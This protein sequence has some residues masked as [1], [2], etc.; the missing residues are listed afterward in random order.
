MDNAPA[1]TDQLYIRPDALTDWLES[2]IPQAPDGFRF[3]ARISPKATLVE[4]LLV[5]D[6]PAAEVSDL[7]K[8]LESVPP[9]A[10]ESQSDIIESA[11]FPSEPLTL[12]H[13]VS[14][15]QGAQ[16]ILAIASTAENNRNVWRALL[17]CISDF[18]ESQNDCL[19]LSKEN[20]ELR[21]QE[22]KYHGIFDNVVEGIYQTSRDG[23]YLSVNRMLAQIYGYENPQALMENIRNIQRDLYVDPA[24]RE[25]FVR[26]LERDAM[27]SDFESEVRRADGTAIWIS[28]NA[29][30]VAD[31][32]GEVL[33][34]E[35]TVQDIS[36]RKRAEHAL[37]DSEALYHSLVENISQNIFRKN[38]D[39]VFTFANT[40]FCETLG[41]P[42][43]EIVGKTDFDFFPQALAE[44]YTLDDKTVLKTLR[45]LEATEAYQDAA[46]ERFYVHVIKTPL[47]AANGDVIGVQGIFHD[48]T[49]QKKT[50]E[51]LAFERDLHEALMSS[52]PDRIY[53]KNIDLKYIKLSR[54]FIRDLGFTSADQA[55]GKTDYDIYPREKA[56][57]YQK[58]DLQ[59]IK[60]GRPLI[61]KEE[62]GSGGDPT[63]SAWVLITK[64]PIFN[65]RGETTGVVGIL[66][67]ITQLKRAEFELADARDAAL[68]SARVKAE[69]LAN[70]SHEIRTPMNAIIGNTELLVQGALSDE[71]R[72]LA[73]ASIQSA[74]AL[75]ALMN[76]ILDFSKME[77]GKLQIESIPID[78]GALA[79]SSLEIFIQT[80]NRKG[81]ELYGC[82]KTDVPR[83]LQGDPVRIRQ[84][85]INLL[86]NAVKFT[87]Q[88]EIRVDVSVK[89]QSKHR[90]TILFEVSDTGIGIRKEVI[91][92]L[93][94][95]FTQADGSMARRFGGAGL[96]LAIIK[97]LIHLMKGDIGVTSEPNKGSS[98]W[99][100]IPFLNIEEDIKA[101]PEPVVTRDFNIAVLGAH[102]PELQAIAQ[103]AQSIGASAA[104]TTFDDLNA[105]LDRWKGSQAPDLVLINAPAKALDKPGETIATIEQI[106]CPLASLTVAQSKGFA[107]RLTK[108]A[109]SKLFKPLRR[110]KLEELIRMRLRH[111][112]EETLLR[113][114]QHQPTTTPPGALRILVAEDNEFN[115][116]LAERQF[117]SLGYD[118]EIASDGR[119]ALERLDKERY[120]IVFM[121]CQMPEMDGYTATQEIRK[122]EANRTYK[123]RTKIIAMTANA[124][125]AD[126]QRC[127]D[128]GMDAYIPKPVR[129]NQLKS[130]LR[131]TLGESTQDAPT[132]G[133]SQSERSNPSLDPDAPK[134]LNPVA[135]GFQPDSAPP[136]GVVNL[137]N[138][139]FNDAERRI[140]TIRDATGSD[141]SRIV[142][143]ELHSLK[144]SARNLGAIRLANR[145]EAF[146]APFRREETT[147]TEVITDDLSTELNAL[148]D[149]LQ[150]F[151]VQ[152]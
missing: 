118:V 74:E 32:N 133:S 137:V 5:R 92:K 115:Q 11:P 105:A 147:A 107:E 1:P 108:V 54:A 139:F 19:E 17:R 26:R 141:A 121:D 111:E 48:V 116:G 2:V 149:E 51:A 130:L 36:K 136:E 25:E 104:I 93:F 95:A 132:S 37:M 57:E 135:M 30:R 72:E 87:N 9:N 68:E 8:H 146:E 131:E 140:Q 114:M 98:F 64:F 103:T 50:E 39:G 134:I 120:D 33:Y 38:V 117:K 67:D 138:L 56:E 129:I 80:T 90:T 66:R 71:Q 44:K 45:P 142:L 151:G 83:R 77:A 75:Q 21:K 47:Y 100:E 24:R 110:Q 81:I 124:M 15:D 91:P 109:Q 148:R 27:I 112:S 69:F 127:I 46:G 53:Y 52:S 97:H 150:Q 70:M 101:E 113:E 42:L 16:Y 31:E 65:Q 14:K 86:N 76:D 145:C 13:R 84:I 85:L 79:E 55:I 35:G 126:Y 12:F 78:V 40:K 143:A 3:L 59:I 106:P 49:A 122:R 20:E 6:F 34:Y 22:A 41:R 28:E 96:G 119:Q 128:C 144:G 4:S 125:P 61:N 123:H 102:E 152:V 94:Q 82:V 10:D 18:L 89:K 73:Q 23:T 43:D 29:R 60:T 58:E 62:Q 88:G 99:F 7:R 63:E